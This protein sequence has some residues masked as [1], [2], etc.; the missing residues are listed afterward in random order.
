MKKNYT[1]AFS[2][3]FML[4]SS[5]AAFAQ[6][7][8][9]TTGGPT[10]TADSDLDLF[11]FEHDN[12]T[13]DFQNDCAQPVTGIETIA[14]TSAT[15]SCGT[16]YS[17]SFTTGTCGGNFTNVLEVW[18]DYDQSGTFDP[19]ESILFDGSTLVAST[20]SFTFTVPQT[21]SLGLTGMR[22]VQQETNSLGLDPCASFSWGSVLDLTVD[23][24]CANSIA[25]CTEPCDA[26]FDPLANIS[27]PSLCSGVS[28][29]GCTNPIALN[30]DP[31]ALVDDGSC[32]NR[33]GDNCSFPDPNLFI[34]PLGTPD[35]LCLNDTV[36]VS[37]GG[38]NLTNSG[39]IGT[40]NPFAGL[41][42]VDYWYSW[43]ATVPG[44]L[45]N[46]VSPIANLGNPSLT[47]Y[48]NSCPSP[49]EIICSSSF[50]N[51]VLLGGW[52][53]G[54]TL[55]LQ[56]QDGTSNT[57][58]DQAFCLK[59]VFSGC[60]NPIANNYNPNATQDDG[61]C[62]IDSS[63]CATANILSGCSG[64]FVQDTIYSSIA[65]VRMLTLQELM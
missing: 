11:S 12:G 43:V 33:I 4:L 30:Y 39:I 17:G 60:T 18:I 65:C 53:I 49:S 20:D 61:S 5:I 16:S 45:F 51:N 27:D 64:A 63:N 62:D 58:I 56:I 24:T 26:N 35:S 46:S 34:N 7:T 25:G 28:V 59:E 36:F 47:I 23:V 31:T 19:N 14:G 29:C 44:L 21:A 40:C 41:T 42:T 15:F 50:S 9:C 13:Y 55:L 22:I 6:P 37:L 10:S 38:Y 52:N 57:F 48:D 32:L 8:Y 3:F 54:D 2:I 1:I